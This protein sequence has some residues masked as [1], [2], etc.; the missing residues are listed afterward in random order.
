MDTAT[1][2]PQAGATGISNAR[3]AGLFGL[4]AL[5]FLGFAVALVPLYRSFCELTGFNGT[6][7]AAPAARPRVVL[8][9]KLGVEFIATTM[10]GLPW[11]F[12]PEQR[13]VEVHPGEVRTIF[14]RASNPTD[15]PVTARAVMSVTPELAA[16]QFRKINCFCFQTQTLA[17][18]ETRR[19]AVMFY[20]TPAI[21]DEVGTITLSYAVFPQTPSQSPPS[22]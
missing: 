21:S 7:A 10:P 13:R 14:Y 4:M 12:A 2:A 3:L 15:H 22:G 17:A 9:R 20:V 5:L 8:A 19:L 6:T 1:A 18:H 11:Q 16:S